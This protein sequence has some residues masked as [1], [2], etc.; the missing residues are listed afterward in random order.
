MRTTSRCT[1]SRSCQQDAQ[2]C[3]SGLFIA[4]P[5]T[6]T[7][8][9]YI[10]VVTLA[11]W[12]LPNS[13]TDSSI[14]LPSRMFARSGLRLAETML[15]RQ[16]ISFSTAPLQQAQAKPESDSE[17]DS[18]NE[19]ERVVDPEVL[20]DPKKTYAGGFIAP[21][22]GLKDDVSKSAQD[23]LLFHPVYTKEYV[24]SVVPKHKPPQL[25][26]ERIGYRVCQ[27]ARTS[28]DY[29]T[30]YG[31][32]MDEKKFLRRFIFLETIA[33]VPGMVGGMLRHLQSL[34][35]MRRDNGWIHTLLEEA[36]NER[37]HLLTFLKLRQPGW[38]FRMTVMGAQGVFSNIY[39]LSYILSPRVCHA[40]VGYLE[41]EAV[42]TY[43]HAIKD[44]EAGK[45]P[46]WTNMPAP[47]IAIDYWKLGKDANMRDLLLAAACDNLIVWD[48]SD[49]RPSGHMKLVGMRA[50]CSVPNSSPN[51]SITLSSRMFAR[52]GLRLA[53]AVLCRA[54]LAAT[55][56]QLFVPSQ[57]ISLLTAPRQQA[58]AKPENDS[59][60]ESVNESE[61]VVDPATPD[62]P[63]KTYAG[64]Y[65]APHPGL[66]DDVSTPD[67]DYFLSH[68]IY[69]KDYVESVVPKHKPPQLL[70]E[71]IGYRVC[72]FARTSF[73]YFTGYGPNM[74]EKKFL[75]RF[76]FLETIA[77]VPGMVGGML[78][79]LQ[80]LR[81]M[82]RDNGW[83]HTLLEE[84]ENERM[85]L[86][87]FLKLRE[88]KWLFRMTVLGAQG[89]FCNIYFLSYILSPRVC[90]AF[91][92]YL[93]EEAVRTYTHAIQDLEAGKLPKWTNMPA[94]DIAIDYWK[95]GK[96][97]NMRDL[98]LAVR[99]DEACH[100]HVN[101]TFSD[102]KPDERNPFAGHKG[103]L[104]V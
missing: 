63:K 53:E 25:L 26:R 6:P 47:D 95:L 41:E 87:T 61:R 80:S 37:M 83:I 15:C 20:N 86:L 62:D 12:S 74:D 92:G 46:E 51:S 79:H 90:H 50:E 102:I 65:I 28:F 55:P 99:A 8:P 5:T 13:S 48:L 36:E 72:Q 75:R 3:C 16:P 56:S 11:T 70:R 17:G 69:T 27:F 30:G 40:F 60:G 104:M 34:R 98:L 18:V 43:S 29:F 54:R 91:V 21:H 78:R 82:R 31:P 9:G 52:S 35:L 39:F 96:D 66:K 14:V 94:P 93:E 10:R 68:P 44:L 89:V 67:Q 81:L 59:E 100:S 22:P 57:P 32:N 88:P 58:Q 64:G 103:G 49:A 77:G 2:C 73:D 23:Y 4:R 84:A 97:A 85:H 19:S 7:R 42:R 71:R 38:F 76:I 33:G 101:H 24:E 1:P 45:L